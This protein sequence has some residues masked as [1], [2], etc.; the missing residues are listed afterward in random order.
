[1]ALN[2]LKR[3]I[4]QDK[5]AKRYTRTTIVVGEGGK[6]RRVVEHVS[7]QEILEDQEDYVDNPEDPGFRAEMEGD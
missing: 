2:N 7:L 6:V 1:M 4:E 5:K 3:K